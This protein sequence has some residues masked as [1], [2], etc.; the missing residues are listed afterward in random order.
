MNLTDHD[1]ASMFEWLNDLAKS[2]IGLNS[3]YY[4]ESETKVL[5]GFALGVIDQQAEEIRQLHLQLDEAMLWR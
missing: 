4:T 1:K 5:A 2:P 3:H